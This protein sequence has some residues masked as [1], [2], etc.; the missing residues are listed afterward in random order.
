M[1]LEMQPDLFSW[2]P[3]APPASGSMQR[4]WTA[5]DK[6]RL[7]A[8]YLE[9]NMPDVAAIARALGRSYSNVACQ[10]SR[11]GLAFTKRGVNAKMRRC[12]RQCGRDFWSEG[13]ENRV[14]PTCKRSREYLE[15]A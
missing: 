9:G 1:Q 2:R 6:E 3:V 10:A 8:L 4:P 5:R 14:C 15:C 12:I 13:F 11:M 7:A